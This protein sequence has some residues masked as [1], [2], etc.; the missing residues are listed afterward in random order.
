MDT[1]MQVKPL[2]AKCLA[3]NLALMTAILMAT[4]AMLRAGTATLVF[5]GPGSTVTGSNV[6]DAVSV[7]PYTA[8]LATSLPGSIRT[9]ANRHPSPPPPPPCS[10]D[11]R[12]K[13]CNDPVGAPE[14]PQA[15]ILAAELLL[16]ALAAVFLLRRGLL[17]VRR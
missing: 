5:T 10:A 4:A 1:P 6:L 2:A 16:F 13:P 11:S 8:T 14:P 9:S 12:T 17:A 7:G 15:E 3:Q